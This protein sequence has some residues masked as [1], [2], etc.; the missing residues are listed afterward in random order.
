MRSEWYVFV[1][2]LCAYVQCVASLIAK[3]K[4][5]GYEKLCC[6]RCIQT[7][8]RRIPCAPTPSADSFYLPGHELPRFNVYLQSS[9]GPAE[10][11]D[12]C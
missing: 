9:E 6:L 8:V 7:R 12:G 10:A 5:A 3:W 2:S 1:L 11:R 4:K